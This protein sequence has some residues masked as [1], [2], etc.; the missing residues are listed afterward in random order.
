[1]A[2]QCLQLQTRGNKTTSLKLFFTFRKDAGLNP[3]WAVFEELRE[4]A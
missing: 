2:A 1:M 3:V 4:K